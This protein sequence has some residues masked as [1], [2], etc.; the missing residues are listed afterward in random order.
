L[1]N[2]QWSDDSLAATVTPWTRSGFAF[3]LEQARDPGPG[4]QAQGHWHG[5]LSFCLPQHIDGWHRELKLVD[6]IVQVPL[7]EQAIS[8]WEKGGGGAGG[9]GEGYVNMVY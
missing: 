3:I 8:D 9:G 6:R 1:A 5:A 7:E 2:H 4:P